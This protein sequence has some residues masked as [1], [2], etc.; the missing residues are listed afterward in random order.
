MTSELIFANYPQPPEMIV[1]SA[2]NASL[3]APPW[4]MSLY[5]PEIVEVFCENASLF[6][7]RRWR[8]ASPQSFEI[9]WHLS[10]DDFPLPSSRGGLGPTLSRRSLRPFSR[11]SLH[12][13]RYW[14]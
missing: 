2:K 12:S 14:R 10:E 13:F 1:I 4:G 3:F 5:L 8:S 7:L 11:R 6:A 9:I